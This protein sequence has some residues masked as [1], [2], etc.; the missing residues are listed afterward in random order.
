MFNFINKA[1]GLLGFRLERLDTPSL[2]FQR[3]SRL[4]VIGT[5]IFYAFLGWF[6]ISLFDIS[7]A[8]GERGMSCSLQF[9][10][11]PKSVWL[12]Y[13]WKTNRA[14]IMATRSVFGLPMDWILSSN[15]LSRTWDCNLYSPTRIKDQHN[16]LPLCNYV[17]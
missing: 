4:I 17:S 2:Q 1:L 8:L 9:V 16:I 15:G 6:G 3:P 12:F 7:E 11:S 13:F 14:K 10:F 5:T